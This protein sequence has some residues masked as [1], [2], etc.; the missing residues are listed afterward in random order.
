MLH[1]QARLRLVSKGHISILQAMLSGT[2]A[3]KWVKCV[4]VEEQGDNQL[5]GGRKDGG[6]GQRGKFLMFLGAG[7]WL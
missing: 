5:G 4:V 2:S 3:R 1:S 6:G 7:A